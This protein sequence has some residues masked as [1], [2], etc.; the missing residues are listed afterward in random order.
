MDFKMYYCIDNAYFAGY[1]STV[2]TAAS[3]MT[4]ILK[5]MHY[6]NRL[7]AHESQNAKK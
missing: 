2:M 3:V 4:A 6:L 5:L 1:N 7:E